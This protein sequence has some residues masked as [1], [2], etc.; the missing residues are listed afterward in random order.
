MFEEKF[1]HG[2]YEVFTELYNMARNEPEEETKVFF[3]FVGIIIVNYSPE[4]GLKHLSYVL[5]RTLHELPEKYRPVPDN[6][7]EK[8]FKMVRDFSAHGEEFYKNVHLLLDFNEEENNIG[9]QH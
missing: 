2:M 8:V 7:M 9:I 4:K 6:I 5:W 3:E 1:K